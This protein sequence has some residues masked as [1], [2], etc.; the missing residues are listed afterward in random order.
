MTVSKQ[1]AISVILNAGQQLSQVNSDDLEELHVLMNGIFQ[2]LKKA[3]KA[4]PVMTIAKTA[5]KTGNTTSNNQSSSNQPPPRLTEE[6]YQ[7]LRTMV[8]NGKKYTRLDALAKVVYNNP[9][10]THFLILKILRP[11]LRDNDNLEIEIAQ[12]RSRKYKDQYRIKNGSMHG[13]KSLISDSYYSNYPHYKNY[14][15]PSSSATTTIVTYTKPPRTHAQLEQDIINAIPNASKVK[16]VCDMVNRQSSGSMYKLIKEIM[17]DYNL[18]LGS[19][20][21]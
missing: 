3:G 15:L 20:L 10:A 9:N 17:K 5:K 16:H 18:R 6:E 8:D 19:N 1:A 7:I 21:V 14:F 4:P 13:V 12:K 2:A 11:I